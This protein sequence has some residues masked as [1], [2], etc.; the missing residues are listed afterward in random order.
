MA[1]PSDA[2]L[3]WRKSCSSVV[4]LGLAAPCRS[5]TYLFRLACAANPPQQLLLPMQW[6]A[7]RLFPSA[8][9]VN[10]NGNFSFNTSASMLPVC[11]QVG[12]CYKELFG[13]TF[14]LL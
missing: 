11:I 12:Q 6:P 4:L 3:R 7:Q 13:A 14:Q 5:S 9:A 10:I 8:A 2:P 1:A